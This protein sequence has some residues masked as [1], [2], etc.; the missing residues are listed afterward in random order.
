MIL[1]EESG[2]FA[3][4][5]RDLGY[6]VIV[7][8]LKLDPKNGDVILMEHYAG[9]LDGLLMFPTCTHNAGS[10]A[11]WWESKGEAAVRE[12]LALDDA[13]LRQ[14]ALHPELE[15]WMLEQPVGRLPKWYGPAKW[16]FQ[17][18][19]FAGWADD[20]DS[21]AYTK[22]TCLWG[23]FNIPEKKEVEPVLGSIMHQ[24][25]GGKSEKTKE[26]RSKTPSGF[27]RAFVAA[28]H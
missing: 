10:G 17:P 23:K 20:P 21:E 6:N 22:R 7:K 2:A 11:R 24:K 19:E 15:F 16:N 14:V 1:C 4:L 28:N 12:M 25:Y 27:A 5:Y 18:H 9:H 8:D 26:M 3:D 13:C